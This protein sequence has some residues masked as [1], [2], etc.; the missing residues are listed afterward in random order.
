MEHARVQLG[1][2]V[3]RKAAVARTG[4][5]VLWATRTAALQVL[6]HVSHDPFR[7]KLARGR[8]GA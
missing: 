7:Q 8:R 6:R 2:L 5:W 4:D 3:F 1:K